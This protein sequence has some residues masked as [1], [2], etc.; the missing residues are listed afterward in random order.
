MRIRYLL[1][2][3]VFALVL[4]S[5]NP[6]GN[7]QTKIQGFTQGTT[8]SVIWYHSP[9][10]SVK[11][12]EKGIGQLLTDI[13]NSLSTYNPE[14]VI[15][16]VN[17]NMEVELDTLF[18]NVFNRSYEIWELTDGAFDIT[19]APLINAWGFG[20]DATKRF[21]ESIKDRLMELVGMD[22]IRIEND[23]VIKN[24]PGISLDVNAIAQ[25]Y[26]VDL[27]Y[28][29][30]DKMGFESF[31]VE[32][33]GEVRTKGYKP[34][35]A[36]WIVGLDKPIDGNITPGVNRQADIKL[37]DKALATSGNYRK[38]YIEDGVKYSHTIDP[39]TG[40]PVKH[41]LLSTTIIT[42]DCMTAD[43]LATACMVM[44]L[45]KAKEFIRG[46][47]NVQAYMVYSDEEGVFNTWFTEGMI[48]YLSE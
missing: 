20:P 3:I 32:I 13:D 33:G 40:Y 12:I 18:I 29:Y 21:N 38:F 44:G 5:C 19:A 30:L 10:S 36:P 43:A 45:E 48:E 26:S 42:Y 41:K 34:E 15:S 6:G 2:F 24:D 4:C 14:S 9:L 27:V 31:L 22:K 17:N 23:V 7:Q 35:D 39:K 25:G 16:K 46:L 37:T 28:N 1:M 11:K 8:Y 47:D